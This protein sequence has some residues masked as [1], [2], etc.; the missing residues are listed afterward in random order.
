MKEEEEET[1][2]ELTTESKEALPSSPHLPTYPTY[3]TFRPS[4]TQCLR[5]ETPPPERVV[6]ETV[7]QADIQLSLRE[8]VE[9]IGESVVDSHEFTNPQRKSLGVSEEVGNEVT[10][11]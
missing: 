5:G 8:E 3:P 10:L 7:S 9:D 4:C 11:E 6:E 1:D 2:S